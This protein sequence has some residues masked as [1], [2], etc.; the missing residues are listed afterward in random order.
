MSVIARLTAAGV[1]T[2]S[3]AEWGSVRPAAYAKRRETHP[4]PTGPAPYHFL[5]ITV[6]PDTDTVLEGKNG[7]RKVESYGLSTP[8]MVSYQGLTTNEG[9]WFE[10]QSFGVKGTHTI[11]DKNVPGFPHDLNRY[12]YAQAIMQNVGDEVTDVQVRTVAMAFAAAELDG[13]VKH[14][15]PIYPHQKF[16]AKAC[17]GPKAIA[18]LPEI[19]RLK[20]Y[21]V[22]HGLPKAGTPTPKPPVQEDDMSPEQMTELK[23]HV[24]A[25]AKLY[26]IANNNYTRQVLSTAT[27][28]I[29]AASDDAEQAIAELNAELDK[30]DAEMAKDLDDIAVKVATLPKA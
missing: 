3:R 28:A 6:T 27:K 10:G 2:Y 25:M 22:A 20:D 1:E 8:P 9:K 11:N 17:P 7:A 19:Q 21:Y 18:R 13:F 30:R 12:G 5:H 15:A 14:G 16:A 24:T 26:A 23:D 29:L 4:M